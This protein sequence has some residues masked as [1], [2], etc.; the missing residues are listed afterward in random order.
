MRYWAMTKW[1]YYWKINAP[2]SIYCVLLCLSSLVWVYSPSS[3][4]SVYF[5]ARIRQ[6]TRDLE[7]ISRDIVHRSFPSLLSC[8]QRCQLHNC[9]K[10]WV[11]TIVLSYV[12][13]FVCSWTPTWEVASFILAYSIY[14]HT[15]GNNTALSN[16]IVTKHDVL[17]CCSVILNALGAQSSCKC[18]GGCDSQGWLLV[19]LFMIS[20]SSM[21]KHCWEMATTTLLAHWKDQPHSASLYEELPSLRARNGAKASLRFRSCW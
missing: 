6:V 9:C 18:F 1:Q 4:C 11:S 15:Y 20:I 10:Y 7:P 5:F 14:L 13:D 16:G 8:R 21:T 17:S 3:H 12:L 19:Y 2:L